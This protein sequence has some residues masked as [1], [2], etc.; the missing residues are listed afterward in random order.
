MF[1]GL[2]RFICKT[3]DFKTWNPDQC[4]IR[5]ALFQRIQI[6]DILLFSHNDNLISEEEFL[7]LFDLNKS[8]N[9]KLP[10]W[11]YDQFDLDHLT[12][13]ECTSDFR[14]Y[15]RDVYLFVEVLQI[16]DEIRCCNRV[17]VDGIEALCIFLKRSAYPCRYSDMLAR[18]AGK[19]RS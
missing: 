8:R 13:D 12:D 9:L 7:L 4:F 10:Y 5:D 14:F 19:M 3:I 16:P 17:I 6:R 11:S 1:I 15:G 2:L 18:F